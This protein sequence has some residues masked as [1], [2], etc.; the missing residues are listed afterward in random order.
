MADLRMV[1][2]RQFAIWDWVTE[3]R[4]LVL[5]RV[6]IAGAGEQVAAELGRM[7]AVLGLAD[8]QGDFPYRGFSL[9]SDGKG[10]LTSVL[11]IKGDIWLMEDFDRRIGWLD[12]LLRRR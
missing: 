3:N 7:P 5:G 12:R 4:R 10:F 9:S 2:R 1:A 8:F 6:E 11:A